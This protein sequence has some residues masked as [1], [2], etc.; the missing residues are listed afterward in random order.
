MKTDPVNFVPWIG[1]SEA[2]EPGEVV[3][4]ELVGQAEAEAHF[5][6]HGYGGTSRQG[7]AGYS[8]ISATMNVGLRLKE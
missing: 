8:N 5:V 4:V 6:A 1:D 3:V 2:G 7:L